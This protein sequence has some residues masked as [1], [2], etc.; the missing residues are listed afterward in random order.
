MPMK[1]G[2]A[3]DKF[4]VL[5]GC[6]LGKSQKEN[7]E[8]IFKPYWYFIAEVKGRLVL[9]CSPAMPYFS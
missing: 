6:P 7:Q 3:F 9:S 4:V 1:G 5:I 2:I 8:L